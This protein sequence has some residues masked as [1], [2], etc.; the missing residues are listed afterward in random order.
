MSANN[1]G[2][3]TVDDIEKVLA[4]NGY[5]LGVDLNSLLQ[6]ADKE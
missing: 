3:K 1:C 2:R 6:N 4:D 5:A